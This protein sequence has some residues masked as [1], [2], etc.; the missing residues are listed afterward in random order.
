MH[1]KAVYI[2]FQIACTIKPP[3]EQKRGCWGAGRGAHNRNRN[4]RPN[5]RETNFRNILF[6]SRTE[7]V[8]VVLA[9]S[10]PYFLNQKGAKT[11]NRDSCLSDDARAH[12]PRGGALCQK[13][14]YPSGKNTTSVLMNSKVIKKRETRSCYLYNYLKH[15]HFQSL[16]GK[17]Q[18]CEYHTLSLGALVFSFSTHE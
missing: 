12:F 18:I 11:H 2:C 8:R 16:Q 7:R 17:G 4:T 14:I 13:R 6:F 1:R 3:P 10:T 15:V 5:Q 9:Q